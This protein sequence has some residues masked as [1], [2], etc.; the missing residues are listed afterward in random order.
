MDNENAEE[1]FEKLLGFGP[2][3]GVASI[4]LI[5]GGSVVELALEHRREGGVECPGCG[6]VVPLHDHARERK[7]RHLDMLQYETR[8]RARIPRCDCQ[9]CG[10]RQ[11]EVPWAAPNARFTLLFE[12]HA[13][14]VLQ[15]ARSTA[16]ACDL[17]NIA[18]STADTIM[19]R[20]VERGLERREAEDLERIGMDEKSFRARHRYITSL[21]DLDR[22]RVIEVV[23]GR[24]EEKAVEL[25]ESL[26]P[27]ARDGIKAVALDMWPAFLSAVNTVLPG[28]AIV[29]DRFHISKH[30]NEGVNKVRAEEHKKLL[31]KGDDRLK[32]TRNLWLW[33]E[34]NL[35]D[36]QYLSFRDI[37]DSELKTSKAWF[38]KESF[39]FFW[40]LPKREAEAAEYFE[41][42]YRHTIYSKLEPMKKVARM[43]KKHLG[44]IL[45]WW[46]HRITNAVSEGLN[47]KIQSVKSA[48]RGFHSFESYR[49]RILFF[50]GK[51]DMK[52]IC[53]HSN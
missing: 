7:W 35:S 37:K 28:A 11:I 34:D 23:E 36:E 6:A 46:E 32:G 3:W 30:L 53:T 47:S 44:N 13:I 21:C 19:K 42:W 29:H 17:L 41:E 43:L 24:T 49:T 33:N 22:G 2:D 38:I 26:S 50:C 14:E 40:E 12:A 18:W 15:A 51:L 1:F 27:K 45:T 16:Q 39:R 25:L 4:E 31:S 5:D 20:G 9:E 8:I 48:A 52:P 10:V